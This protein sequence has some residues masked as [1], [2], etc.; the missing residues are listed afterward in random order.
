[1]GKSSK[2]AESGF[3][4]PNLVTTRNDNKLIIFIVQL[5]C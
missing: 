2:K 4:I 3:I 5:F 1:M